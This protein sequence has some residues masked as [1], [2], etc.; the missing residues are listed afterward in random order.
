VAVPPSKMILRTRM[1]MAL[2]FFESEGMLL[3]PFSVF[4]EIYYFD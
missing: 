2:R 4:N 1:Q 3:S